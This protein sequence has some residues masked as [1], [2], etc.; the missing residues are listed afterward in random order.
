MDEKEWVDAPPTGQFE[1]PAPPEEPSSPTPPKKKTPLKRLR[2]QLVTLGVGL[3]LIAVAGIYFLLQGETAAP[4]EVA[5]SGEQAFSEALVGEV[6]YVNPL[7]ATTQAERDLTSLVFSGLTRVDEFGQPVPDLAAGWEVS[8]DGLTYTFTLR[9]DATWHDGEAVTAED[10]AFTFALLRDPDFPGPEALG[11]FWQT[12]ETYREDEFT[13]RFVLTQPLTA[14]PEYAGIGLLPEHWLQGVSAAELPEDPFNL[15][16][17]GSGRLDWMSIN[18]EGAAASI[19]LEPYA[20]YYEADRRI[21]LD[22]AQFNIYENAGAAFSALGPEVQA[23][24]GLGTQQLAAALESERLNIYTA[25]IPAY[26]AVVFNQNSEQV[27]F[28]QEAEVRTALA[29]ALER[30]ALTGD[31]DA[32]TVLTDSPIM[33]GTWAYNA[34]L[35]AVTYSPQTAEQQLSAAG[36]APE[37]NIRSREGQRLSFTLLTTNRPLDEAAAQAIREQ[38]RAVGVDVDVETVRPARFLSRLQ[39]R[40]FDAALVEFSQ[41][42][43]AD[44]DPYAFWHD[45]QIED[46]QNFSGVNDR[47]ISE[48]LEIARRDPN[49]VRRA[50]LYRG[51]QQRFIEQ[52]IAIPLYNPAYHY[53]VSCQVMG[54]QVVILTDPSDRFRM[55]HEWRIAAP[56]ELEGGCP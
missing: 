33:P 26:S 40:N 49:G 5:L 15:D 2:W 47:E 24:G 36:W 4:P 28:F 39:G 54:V 16:P 45:S 30:S 1:K 25:R 31:Y 8:E 11:R 44:P 41:G 52:M 43:I 20:D 35:P 19:R 22:S 12:V 17:I 14:F 13:V 53:A 37:G 18:T 7:L 38:W 51:F 6:I 3:L 21:T 48:M 42:G 29:L 56:D 34:G 9:E 23:M 27:P 46:G 10:V 55:M 32:M 50:E